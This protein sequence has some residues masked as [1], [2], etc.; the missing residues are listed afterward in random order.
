MGDEEEELRLLLGELAQESARLVRIAAYTTGSSE[1]ATS[2]H[3]LGALLT[4]GPQRLGELA[5]LTRVSQPGMTKIVAALVERGW[6]E[7][8]PDPEDA[9]AWRIEA[10]PAGRAAL[11]GWLREMSA[12]LLPYFSG[13]GDEELD[14]L[15]RTV[16]LLTERVEAAA[17]AAV[18]IAVARTAP[19]DLPPQQLSGKDLP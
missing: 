7:R 15:R 3:T 18:R 12:A 6:L 14:A 8:S 16:R 11:D 19:A 4:H 1:P 9:R 13:L 5:V 10:T 2:W 17:P